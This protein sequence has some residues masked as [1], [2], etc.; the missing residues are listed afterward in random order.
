MY[1][2]CVNILMIIILYLSILL[3]V[4]EFRIQV[5]RLSCNVLGLQHVARET[6]NLN[7]EY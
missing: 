1:L 2:A 7:T 3:H 6:E 4:L 5:L